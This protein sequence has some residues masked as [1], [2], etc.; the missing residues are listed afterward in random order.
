MT[1]R[2]RSDEPANTLQGDDARLRWM[3][4]V[5][6]DSADPI[7]IEDLDGY[8]IDMNHEAERAYGWTR[9]RLIGKPILV[10]VPVER[11]EQAMDL[12]R[13]CKAGEDVRNVDGQRQTKSGEVRDVLLTLS[14]LRDD[15]GEPTGI[16]SIA[17]DLSLIHISEPTRQ[18]ATSRMP[19]SA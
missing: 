3:T 1:E 17:K 10:I 11:H 13:R 6:M 9:E 5:F 7:L 12:L 15:D 14:L 19:S 4:R 2:V 16:A 18:P 8:V